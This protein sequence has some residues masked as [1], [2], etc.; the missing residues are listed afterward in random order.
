MR[1]L[2]TRETYE[3]WLD[4]QG[5]RAGLAGPAPDSAAIATGIYDLAAALAVHRV[6][7]DYWWAC[8]ASYARYADPCVMLA[9]D[10][11]IDATLDLKRR[12]LPP[13]WYE[14][15]T[16]RML[17]LHRV[18]QDG[19]T[20]LDAMQRERSRREADADAKRKRGRR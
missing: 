10:R 15:P 17:A 5:E 20:E 11:A 4:E 19:L 13:Q 18:A 6:T 16:P 2:W 7:G 8:P 3:V 14:S 9:A 1:P 12:K